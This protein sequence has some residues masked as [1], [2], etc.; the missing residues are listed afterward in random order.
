MV[1]GQRK[2]EESVN[3]YLY[4]LFNQGEQLQFR[5]LMAAPPS[6]LLVYDCSTKLYLHGAMGAT[7]MSK[8]MCGRVCLVG[9]GPICP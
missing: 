9:W 6:W 3:M 4:M 7:C 2:Q 5:G 1:R 8:N